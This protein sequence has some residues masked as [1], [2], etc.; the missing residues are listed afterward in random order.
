MTHNSATESKT[1]FLEIVFLWIAGI[2]AAMQFSKFSVSYD[3]LLQ[4]YQAGETLTGAALSLVGVVGLIFG[5]FAGLIASR[6]GYLRVLMG[7][8]FLGG[9]LSFIQASLPSFSVLLIT[10]LLEGFSQLGVVVAAPTLIAKLSAPRHKSLTM[11]LWGTFF[12]VAFAVT[13]WLG[14]NILEQHGIQTLLFGH[15]TLIFTMGVIVFFTL[16]KN[17]VLDM[18]ASVPNPNGFLQQLLQVYR[19][20][21]SLI[22]S[23]VFLC[24]T[25]T[26]VSLLT[27]IPRL[28]SDT[29]VQALMMVCL[30]L[31]STSG[32]FIAGALAQYIM[33]P[34]KVAL[35][36]YSGVALSACLLTLVATQPLWFALMT[37]VLILFLGM[38]PGAAL[39][40]IPA[41]ARTPEEQA[42]GYGLIA[43]FGNLGATIGPPAFA[44]LITLYGLFGLVG[45]VLCICLLGSIFSFIASRISTHK[46]V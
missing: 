1:Q 27:Y 32:T 46:T 23:L 17:A 44:L 21:R 14:K 29:K 15:G 30:P 38:I 22:P 35:M 39:A 7:A 3:A 37:G 40:M 11:G 28:V 6:I 18:S 24:Y 4:Y 26:L 45:M 25:C 34:Q 2:S 19:N 13:G 9:I 42:Q 10:R 20:P 8:L 33:K 36:S 12:G 43:Q 41:L 16:R 5:A 31:L